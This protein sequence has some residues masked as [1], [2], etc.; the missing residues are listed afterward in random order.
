MTVLLKGIL[1][2]V[3]HQ[4]CLRDTWVD[5]EKDGK[6]QERMGRE[7]CWSSSGQYVTQ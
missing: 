2:I 6:L 4:H 5:V 3:D 7:G 1:I